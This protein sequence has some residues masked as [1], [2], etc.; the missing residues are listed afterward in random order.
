L[1]VGPVVIGPI[2]I[3]HI[4]ADRDERLVPIGC[5]KLDWRV[6]NST[7]GFQLGPSYSPR[8]FQNIF[9][10]DGGKILMRPQRAADGFDE[11][12]RRARFPQSFV[13][14]RPTGIWPP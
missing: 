14:P 13:V 3:V 10:E 5:G 6:V 11:T 7:V 9:F 2:F 8:I 12:A 4:R 1:L